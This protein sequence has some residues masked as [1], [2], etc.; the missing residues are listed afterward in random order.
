MS[1]SP[2]S[3][4]HQHINHLSHSFYHFF[5]NL[6]LECINMTSSDPPLFN[7]PYWIHRAQHLYWSE[8]SWKTRRRYRAGLCAARPPSPG[9]RTSHAWSTLWSRRPSGTASLSPGIW[10]SMYWAPQ[11]PYSSAGEQAAVL[12]QRPPRTSW[13]RRTSAAWRRTWHSFCRDG[14]R[15]LLQGTGR[16]RSTT[17][18]ETP[19]RYGILCPCT[20]CTTR[21]GTAEA[22]LPP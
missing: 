19:E 15:R 21:A 10:G 2:F 22:W 18:T 7:C 9:T 14:T 4:F 13:T 20:S 11:Y 12:R 8:P 16:T 17:C 6:F 1:H 5:I 3:L